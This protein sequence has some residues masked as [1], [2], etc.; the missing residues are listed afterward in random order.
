MLNIKN[1]INIVNRCKNNSALQTCFAG[2]FNLFSKLREN[3]FRVQRKAML[4]SFL[5][6]Q[7]LA[8]ERGP[9]NDS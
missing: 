9:P 6:R 5:S 8:Y 3:H 2:A 7:A 4:N 1:L